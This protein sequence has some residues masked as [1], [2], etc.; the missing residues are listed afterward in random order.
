MIVKSDAVVLKS[1]KYRETSKIV[2]LYTRRYGKL[3]VVAKGARQP[4][5]KFG[6]SLESMTHITAIFYRRENRELHT[7]SQAEIRS[8]YFRIHSNLEKLS[9]GLAI[10]DLVSACF[11]DEEENES[12]FRLLAQ[13]LQLL[14]VANEN[15]RNVLFAFEAR[16]VS[17]LGFQPNFKSCAVCR[18]QLSLDGGKR[19]VIFDLARGG[20]LCARCEKDGTRKVKMS[21]AACRALEVFLNGPLDAVTQLTLTRTLE[22]EVNEV[23]SS[24]FRY[25]VG[26]V[27]LFRS[28]EMLSRIVQ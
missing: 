23:L 2:T 24:F 5:S 22:K 4:K 12:A 11:H 17:L 15:T 16:L 25:H 21:R 3:R 19:E 13:T 10:V 8:G 14:D 26:G 7:L 6:G 28:E 9:I 20:L 18:G 1:M 27:K